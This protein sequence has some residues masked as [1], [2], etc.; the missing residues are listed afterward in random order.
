M[1]LKSSVLNHYSLLDRPFRPW[2]FTI[3][4]H[5]AI[6]ALRRQKSRQKSSEA[7]L[8]D[9]V[10]APEDAGQMERDVT[11]GRLLDSLTPQHREAIT[12]T[13]IIGLSNAEAAQRAAISEGAMKLRVHRAIGRLQSLM[14]TEPL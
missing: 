13:K 6:D 2:L 3:V 4:R 11:R 7:E 5:K 1:W 12:L 10:T 14:R 9:S 8:L